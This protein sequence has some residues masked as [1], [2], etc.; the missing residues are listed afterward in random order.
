MKNARIDR[1][2]RTVEAMIHLYC[3]KVHSRGDGLCAACQ[4]LLEYA[5]ARLLRCPFQ[6][7]KPVCVNCPVHCYRP[8]MRERIRKVM[9]YAGPRM[10]LRHPWLALRHLWDEKFG[11]RP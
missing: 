6:E 10:L 2:R 8:D 4:S 7:G 9:R 5:G 11:P 1:E 3:R